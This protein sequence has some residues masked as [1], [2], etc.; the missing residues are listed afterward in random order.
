MPV[1]ILNGSAKKKDGAIRWD[2]ANRHAGKTISH[3][4][5]P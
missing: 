4:M 5:M 1:L 3:S 2:D